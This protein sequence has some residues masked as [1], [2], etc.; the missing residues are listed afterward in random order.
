MRAIVVL[1]LLYLGG[2]CAGVDE[3]KERDFLTTELKTYSCAP[4]G[5]P[6]I[7]V[8]AAECGAGKPIEGGVCKDGGKCCASFELP[9]EYNCGCDFPKAVGQCMIKELC[10]KGD[11][12]KFGWKELAGNTECKGEKEICCQGTME[13]ML[14]SGGLSTTVP[15]AETAAPETPVG[16]E[17]ET[18]DVKVGEPA[19][20]A[21]GTFLLQQ[22]QVHKLSSTTSHRLA[23]HRRALAR[24]TSTV[25]APCPIPTCPGGAALA[26]VPGRAPIVNGCGAEG[27]GI[28]AVV[29]VLLSRHVLTP[30]CDLH[31]ECYERIGETKERCDE[32]FLKDMTGICDRFGFF[33]I[34][35]CVPWKEI[36]Y[37]AVVIGGC[38]PFQTA[39]KRGGCP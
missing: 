29:R 5:S 8:C 21:E 17:A 34:W 10:E 11:P 32:A 1:F 38:D 33:A 31:D 16:T 13:G 6:A 25:G 9:K 18:Q 3:E 39:Q 7:G 20:A 15:A 12:L 24:T 37:Q 35:G 28:D 36:F 27:G 30:A 14:A 4:A 23:R 26:A 22:G 2:V 19:A